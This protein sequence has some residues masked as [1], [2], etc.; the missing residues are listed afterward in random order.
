MA[1]RSGSPGGP[2]VPAHISAHWRI[3]VLATPASAYWQGPDLGTVLR[4]AVR[5]QRPHPGMTIQSDPIAFA[6]S[7]RPSLLASHF[8]VGA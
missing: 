2:I 7:I 1:R 4:G 5:S 8:V 6:V 3:G